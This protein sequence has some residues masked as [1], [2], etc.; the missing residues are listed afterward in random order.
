MLSRAVWI[1]A[2][3]SSNPEALRETVSLLSGSIN[4]VLS[5]PGRGG[6]GKSSHTPAKQTKEILF[7]CNTNSNTNE[8][9]INIIHAKKQGIKYKRTKIIIKKEMLSNR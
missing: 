5:L 8:L 3:A 6:V 4:N 7:V 2:K 9:I 1:C